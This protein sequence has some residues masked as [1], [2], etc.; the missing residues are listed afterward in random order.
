MYQ[1]IA[2]TDLRN[3]ARVSLL[4]TN[5]AENYVDQTV[6]HF[7]ENELSGKASHGMVRVLEA[8]RS[9]HKYGLPECDPVIEK[10]TDQVVLMDAQRQLGTVAGHF[11]IENALERAQ[12]NALSFTGIR[13]YIASCG[14]MAYYLRRITDAGYIALMGCNS[15]ALVAPPAGRKR[16]IGTN[17]VGIGFPSSK[18]PLIADMATSAIAYGKIMVMNE[19]GETVPEGVLIDADGNPSQNPKD[20]YDGAILP[21]ADYKG[22]ALGLMV[23]LLA[24]PL[25]GASAVK[26][27]L[28]DNDGLFVITINPS[29]FGASD[30]ADRIQQ[31]LDIITDTPTRPGSE[32]ITLPGDRSRQKLQ[33]TMD[34][35]IIE[36]AEKTL[37]SL[38]KLATG[39][40]KYE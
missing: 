33:K 32:H 22:F 6:D 4:S 28:Y 39:K 21:L 38:K 1:T 14:S 18:T 40:S 2:I 3:L 9:I 7:L 8:I 27:D 31:T 30:F 35:G 12:G 20:A 11:L 19:T 26:Q 13:N 24:G 17:P 5:L 36:I 37:N 15:V 23:E 16:V 29:H 34:S 25:I 10:Q